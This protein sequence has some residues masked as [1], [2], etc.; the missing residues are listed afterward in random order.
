MADPR[1]LTFNIPKTSA[2]THFNIQFS[3]D[4]TTWNYLRVGGA[5]DLAVALLT[6]RTYVLDGVNATDDADNNK[7]AAS[8]P[9]LWYRVRLKATTAYGQWSEPFVFPSPDDFILNMRRQLSDPFLNGRPALLSVNDYRQKVANAV[10]AFEK[11]HSRET[12]QVYDMTTDDQTYALPDEWS[13]GF[14]FVTGIEYPVGDTPPS[15]YYADAVVVEEVIS[16]WRFQEISPSTGE[17]ARFFYRTRHA[18]DGST[19]PVAF[20]QSV[21]MWATGDAAEHLHMFKNQFGDLMMGSEFQSIDPRIEQ[22][23]QIARRMK[24]QAEKLWGAQVS[25]VRGRVPLYDDH[26]RIPLLVGNQP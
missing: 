24:E 8:T 10:E 26:G 11:M 9:P 16:Q 21:L 17:T 1:I 18:R 22:W 15:L 13:P 2:T 5:T 20:F 14:S 4:Q 6:A 3:N 23:G 12:S 19:V 25:G 7:Q